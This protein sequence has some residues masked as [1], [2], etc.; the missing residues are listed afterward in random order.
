MIKISPFCLAKT[1][2][3]KYKIE[4][5]IN[6]DRG[7]KE[8]QTTKQTNKQTNK[9]KTTEKQKQIYHHIQMVTIL[10]DDK[11]VKTYNLIR[12]CVNDLYPGEKNLFI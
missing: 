12:K 4:V 1:R 7:K 9:Q 10:C 6:V 11:L 8:K 2:D 3:I 5:I